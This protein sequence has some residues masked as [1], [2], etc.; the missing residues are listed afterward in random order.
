MITWWLTFASQLTI[1]HVIYIYGLVELA[2]HLRCRMFP[3]HA[4]GSVLFRSK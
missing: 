4:S 2:E 1:E 3:S